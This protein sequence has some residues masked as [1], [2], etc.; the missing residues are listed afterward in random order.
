MSAFPEDRRR[1]YSSFVRREETPSPTSQNGEEHEMVND[2]D[3]DDFTDDYIKQIFNEE[4]NDEE[5]CGQL[6]LSDIPEISSAL[7]KLNERPSFRMCS[8]GS[9]SRS[10]KSSSVNSNDGMPQPWIVTSCVPNLPLL[11]ENAPENRDD[12]KDSGDWIR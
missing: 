10:T 5:E 4:D 7:E 12:A 9:S 11:N 8:R 2:Q 1:P 3:D 6:D